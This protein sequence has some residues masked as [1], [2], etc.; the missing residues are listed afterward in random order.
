VI[1]G[2]IGAGIGDNDTRP[3]PLVSA[4]TDIIRYW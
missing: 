3:I 4:N 2:D 1:S